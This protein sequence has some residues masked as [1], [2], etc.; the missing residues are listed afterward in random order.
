MT[1]LLVLRPEPGA[2][3][4]MRRAAAMGI[5]ALCYPL[6]AID[7]VAW[8]PPDP[9]NFDA[10][11]LTSANAVRMAGDAL[12]Q[13]RHLPAYAVGQR[14]ADALA[15]AG[16]DRIETGEADGSA[17]ARK[18]AEDGRRHVLHLRGRDSAPIDLGPLRISPVIVYAACERGD[19][20]GLAAMLQ[21][22]IT[23]LVHSAR[24]GRRLAALTDDR[25]RPPIS[26]VA[27]SAAAQTAC[28][29][30]WRAIAAAA[31]PTD[32]A[33]LALARRLCD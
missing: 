13:Y 17:V 5:E 31:R 29:E 2:G 4:T 27:I 15:Q 23:A 7:P 12:P 20:T 1:R 19:A 33:M 3:A 11:M 32:E 25:Q 8:T 10:L 26:I 16:F 21:P 30:G 28:G 14:T 9:A 24:A 22:G 6:F 18:M